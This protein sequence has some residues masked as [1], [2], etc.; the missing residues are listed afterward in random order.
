M[1]R[2]DIFIIYDLERY[3]NDRLKEKKIEKI[4]KRKI[5]LSLI[6]F[7]IKIYW[8]IFKNIY[9]TIIFGLNDKNWYFYY[10]WLADMKKI[11]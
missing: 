2:I 7:I 10:L 4:S 8:N 1:I 9:L 5:F 6:F 3:E 11:D